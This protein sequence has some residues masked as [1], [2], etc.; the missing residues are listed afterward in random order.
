MVKRKASP[1]LFFDSFNYEN[2]KIISEYFYF[3]SVFPF[4]RYFVYYCLLII[5]LS[6]FYKKKKEVIVR[7][8]REI[9][10]NVP[11][12]TILLFCTLFLYYGLTVKHP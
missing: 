9:I 12:Y 1:A 2:L 10:Y 7:E 4:F 11:R 3:D 6:G 8:K 5:F